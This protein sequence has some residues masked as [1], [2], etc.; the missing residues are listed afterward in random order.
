MSFFSRMI[1]KLG[2]QTAS[3]QTES[4]GDVSNELIE[5][6]SRKLTCDE[7]LQ[8]YHDAVVE[9]DNSAPGVSLQDVIRR[10]LPTEVS[11]H[12]LS[13]QDILALVMG[14]KMRNMIAG[15]GSNKIDLR[16]ELIS[17]PSK[18][19]YWVKRGKNKGAAGQFFDAIKC[20][21]RAIKLN[22]H[23]VE[24]WYWKGQAFL[25]LA[26]PTQDWDKVREAAVCFEDGLKANPA[27]R[28]LKEEVRKCRNWLKSA[29]A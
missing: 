14:A 10:L 7:L 24:A 28:R 15:K 4:A 1:E 19:D 22:P 29:P 26:I 16:W 11:P 21:E 17:D 9:F 3:Q 12:K 13:D 25:Q 6:V 18:A 20:F 5:A 8:C 23:E 2:L 27:D